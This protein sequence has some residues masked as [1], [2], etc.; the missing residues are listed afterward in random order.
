MCSQIVLV[1]TKVGIKGKYPEVNCYVLEV[2][3]NC[4]VGLANAVLQLSKTLKNTS[5]LHFPNLKSAPTD[6]SS[7]SHQGYVSSVC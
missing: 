1:C 4:R 5:M 2:S 7:S 6:I 3:S